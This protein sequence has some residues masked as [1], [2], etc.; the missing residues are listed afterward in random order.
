MYNPT[1]ITKY[2]VLVRMVC[3]ALSGYVCNMDIHAAEWKKLEDIV[4][5]LLDRNLGQ[6]HHI[7]LDNF[8][9]SMKLAETLLDRMVRVCGT[10]RANRGIPRDLDQEAS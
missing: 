8:S 6:N 10:M 3:E 9:D 4:L 5:P 2:G 1:K 7:Y